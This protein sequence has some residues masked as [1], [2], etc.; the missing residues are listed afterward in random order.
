MNSLIGRK[1]RCLCKQCQDKQM[2]NRLNMGQMWVYFRLE[3]FHYTCPNCNKILFHIDI[4]RV[5]PVS[6]RKTY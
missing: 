6:G 2:I 4:K 5:I 1:V 3:A